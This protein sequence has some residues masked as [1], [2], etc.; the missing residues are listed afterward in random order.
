M[1]CYY[2][3]FAH[4][5][6]NL[7]L[8]ESISHAKK[9]NDQQ[10]YLKTFFFITACFILTSNLLVIWGILQTK[11]TLRLP[12][13]MFLISSC[14]GLVTCLT[15]PY[16]AVA[17]FLP[18]NCMHETIGDAIL[19]TF[20]NFDFLVLTT[21][22]IFRVISIRSPLTR[23]N[24]KLVIVVLLFEFLVSSLMATYANYLFS[25]LS[26][27]LEIFQIFWLIFGIFCATC[28]CFGSA[29]IVVLIFTLR[30][31]DK[32][33]KD[34]KS[35]STNGKAVK[36]IC[37]IQLIYVI[38][39][40]PVAAISLHFGLYALNPL[41]L[42]LKS[43]ANESI[44]VCWLFPL[45]SYN[46]AMNALIY[47]YFSKGIRKYYL[48]KLCLRRRIGSQQRRQSQIDVSSFSHNLSIK[49]TGTWTF[50]KIL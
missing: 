33:F 18:Q 22:G 11:K 28:I 10:I 37:L 21:V 26:S 29:L 15:I 16:F 23:I 32:K 9:W 5:L 6:F 7:T 13:K 46:C 38:T 17:E 50:C 49:D 25:S 48:N 1:S 12:Q 30:R 8:D 2:Q 45:S 40:L 44:F 24:G 31:Q 20:Q 35:A 14:C 42:N 41:Y 47:M 4:A 39:N 3:G 27:P 43:L 36:R 34:Q 19:A